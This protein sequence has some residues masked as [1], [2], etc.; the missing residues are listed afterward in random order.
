MSLSSYLDTYVLLHL[1][2]LIKEAPYVMGGNLCKDPQM[3]KVQKT[4]NYGVLSP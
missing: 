4:Q 1:A 3:S 2:T